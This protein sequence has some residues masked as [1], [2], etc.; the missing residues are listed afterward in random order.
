MSLTDRVREL[1]HLLGKLLP[2]TVSKGRKTDEEPSQEVDTR[3]IA[4]LS[5]ID[6][7][8]VINY[9]SCVLYGDKLSFKCMNKGRC[10][11]M[12]APDGPV[13][14]TRAFGYA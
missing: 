13:Y 8:P 9:T 14:Q 4:L 7:V 12:E 2:R 11:M 1:K 3:C 6:S 5:T 10:S